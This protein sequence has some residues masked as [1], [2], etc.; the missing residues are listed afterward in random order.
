[1]RV[2]CS[3]F[4]GDDG[5]CTG[6]H[7][8]WGGTFDVAK[9]CSNLGVTGCGNGHGWGALSMWRAVAQRVLRLQP[10]IET[11]VRRRYLAR[12]LSWATP[13]SYAAMHIRRTDKVAGSHAEATLIPTCNYTEGLHGLLLHSRNSRLP[14]QSV[15]GLNVFVATDDFNVIDELQA[16]PIARR[17]TWSFRTFE[18]LGAPR[19]GENLETTLRLW[20]EILLL[21]QAAAVVGT[22]SSNVGRLVQTLREQPEDTFLSLDKPRYSHPM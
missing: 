2:V 15:E 21:K 1:M 16:C 17:H 18:A 7:G 3:N 9:I 12:T 11:H 19:R 13:E 6:L 8:A 14:L 10:E 4:R 20:A 5:N 22:F